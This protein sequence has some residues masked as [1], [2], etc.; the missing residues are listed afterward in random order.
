MSSNADKFRSVGID[1]QGA[2]INPYPSMRAGW[3][4]AIT[5]QHIPTGEE[6]GFEGWVTEFSDTYSSQW[7]SEQVYG[8]M[9]PLATYQ[10]TQRQIQLGFDIVNGSESLAKTNLNKIAKFLQFQYPVYESSGQT[11]Q[12]VLKAAPLLSLKWTNLISSPNNADQKLIGFIEGAVSYAPDMSEGGFLA[13]EV[14]ETEQPEGEG[15]SSTYK[16]QIRNYIPKKVSLSFNFT[17]LHTHLVGWAPLAPWTPENPRLGGNTRDGSYVFG[18]NDFINSRFPNVYKEFPL[19]PPST[20]ARV[21]GD[22]D[23]SEAANEGRTITA[24]GDDLAFEEGEDKATHDANMRRIRKNDLDRQDQVAAIRAPV[25]A[26]PGGGR[27]IDSRGSVAGI[28]RRMRANRR[29]GG[30]GPR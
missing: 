16:R 5:I 4:F 18:G 19:A 22:P 23:S 20:D 10:G 13:G 15:A 6:V 7:N 30:R 2:V 14:V 29:L 25:H 3:F 9:D 28:K 27:S 17:V 12:N 26:G 8:R 1:Y 11:Q 21:E 24:L